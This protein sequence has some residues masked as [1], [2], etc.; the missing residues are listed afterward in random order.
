[1]SVATVT[2]PVSSKSNSEMVSSMANVEKEVCK[3][4][5]KRI[6]KQ[7]LAAK[8]WDRLGPDQVF[9]RTK[10]IKRCNAMRAENGLPKLSDDH[11]FAFEEDKYANI[12][13][14]LS[15][16]L[17][18]EMTL[19]PEAEAFLTKVSQNNKQLYAINRYNILSLIKGSMEQRIVN[20]NVFK[21]FHL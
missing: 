12:P 6:E 9:D 3:D 21:K 15:Y 14:E 18:N 16:K 2:T 7:I 20:H 11:T 1:M 5:G 13:G 17:V 19:T 8:D 4:L 10:F